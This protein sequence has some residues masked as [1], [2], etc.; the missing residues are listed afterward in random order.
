MAITNHIEA[1]N[2]KHQHFETLIREEMVR[3]V[4]DMTTLTNLKKNK[5]LVKEQIQ[6][7]MDDL[8]HAGSA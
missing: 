5:L 1:L 3:P 6:R 4:P 2:A 7:C 8:P